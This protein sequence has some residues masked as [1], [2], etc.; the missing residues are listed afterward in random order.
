MFSGIS[1]GGVVNDPGLQGGGGAGGGRSAHAS[2]VSVN[3]PN[4]NRVTSSDIRMITDA[5][6][7]ELDRRGRRA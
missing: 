1:G 4:I 2:S 7:N 3:L 6:S 5:I